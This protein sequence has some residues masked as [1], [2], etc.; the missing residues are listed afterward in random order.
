VPES[1][2][3]VEVTSTGVKT[4]YSERVPRSA[5]TPPPPGAPRVVEEP[6]EE[7]ERD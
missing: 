6:D 5:K 2:P 4:D 3:H 1:P 7:D